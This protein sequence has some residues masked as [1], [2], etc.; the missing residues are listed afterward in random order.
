LTLQLVLEKLFISLLVLV[1]SL[2]ELLALVKF[3][4]LAAVAGVEP[5]TTQAALVAVAV[6]QVVMF[7][8]LLQ[9]YHLEL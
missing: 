3:F 7:I 1:L 2:L 4:L 8:T 6:E 9:F 5:V